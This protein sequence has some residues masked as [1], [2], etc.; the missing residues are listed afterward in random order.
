MKN[1]IRE[2][3]KEHANMARLLDL[4]DSQVQIFEGAG[5]PDYKVIQEIVHFFLDFP[6]L[7]HHPKED[8]LAQMLLSKAP[9][10]AVQLR[11]LAQKHEELG[12]LTRKVAKAVDQVLG[13]AELPRARIVQIVREF[14]NSQRHHMEMEEEYFLPL[15]DELL[16]R[17]DL[18]VLESEIFQ[19][20]D[21]LFGP[22][23]AKRFENL[24]DAIF[25]AELESSTP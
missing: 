1:I 17:S 25:E 4:L 10:R 3:R 19:T 16:S 14:I 9:S 20:E 13:E 6:D 5:R 18:D 21:P 24:R 2:I 8:I 11:G 22:E 15:A 23:T 12:S 7:C